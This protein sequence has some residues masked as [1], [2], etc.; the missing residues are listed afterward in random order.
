MWLSAGDKFTQEAIYT[1]FQE[2]KEINTTSHS[3]DWIEIE[4]IFPPI[5]YYSD[6]SFPTDYKILIT[7]DDSL[8]S[9]IVKNISRIPEVEYILLL[10]TDN[11]YEIWT[12]INELDREVRDRIYDIEY[13]I[14]EQFPD[15][16]FDFHV[17]CRNNGSIKHIFPTKAIIFYRRVDQ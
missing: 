3:F 4:N 10:S 13:N 2:E 12:V 8:E 17:V 14:L 11:Y 16:Y 15:L 5:I 7:K 6:L 9:F 1:N